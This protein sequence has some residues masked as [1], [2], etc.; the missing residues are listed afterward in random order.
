MKKELSQTASSKF[1]E[2]ECDLACCHSSQY[3]P[4]SEFPSYCSFPGRRKTKAS[5]QAVIILL[6]SV[7]GQSHL[8][9]W[10]QF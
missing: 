9:G 3:F 4:P 1:W 7:L 10:G 8:E 2:E 5:K 6:C